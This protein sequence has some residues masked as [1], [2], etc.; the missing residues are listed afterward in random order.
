VLHVEFAILFSPDEKKLYI[1][2]DS[3]IR[4]FDV[5][6]DAGKLSNGKVF[7]FRWRALERERE[8]GPMQAC[9][10]ASIARNREF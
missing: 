6:I 4:V 7:V 2:D 9:A 1:I 5:D 10:D 3:N 8:G